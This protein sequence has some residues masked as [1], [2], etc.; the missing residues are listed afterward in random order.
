MKSDHTAEAF[1]GVPTMALLEAC[2]EEVCRLIPNRTPSIT[3]DRTAAKAKTAFVTRR[4]NAKSKPFSADENDDLY[5]LGRFIF[6]STKQ[7]R[8]KLPITA[9]RSQA[10]TEE[11]NA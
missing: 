10:P 7:Q 8:K 4:S 6:I 9:D 1:A 3:A 2:S 5:S 11:V